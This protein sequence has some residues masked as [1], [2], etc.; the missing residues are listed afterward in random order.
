MTDLSGLPPLRE[1]IAEHG[2]GARKGLGQHFLLDLNLTR[3]IARAADIGPDDVVIE[4]GP[5][6]GGLTRALLETGA[7]VVAIERDERCR[8]AL[9]EL[10][11]AADGRFDVEFADALQADERAL[12]AARGLAPPVKIASNLPYNVGTELLVRW[13]TAPPG[14]WSRMALMF[15]KEV[16]ERIVASPGTKAYGRLSVLADSASRAKK[17]FDLPA[18]AFTPPP[19]VD[20]SV[21]LF[22]AI[23]PEVDLK[24]LE[25][26]TRA[27][28]GARRKML[29]ASLK[30]LFGAATEETLERLGLDPT[31][32]AEE[33]APADWRRI[34]EEV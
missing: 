16:A 5:G 4:V 2:L 13:L 11:E 9:E 1:T 26:A 25:K 28:F 12:L 23:A 34:A 20:S 30:P 6:P 8:G 15:Q 32:R 18:R 21:V 27:G 7:R 3:K 10:A 29:R 14:L 22:E 24:A 17:A 33:I 31:A 19:K